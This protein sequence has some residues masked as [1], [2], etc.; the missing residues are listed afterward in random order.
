MVVATAVPLVLFAVVDGSH[1]VVAAIAVSGGWTLLVTAAQIVQRGRISPLILLSLAT[2]ALKCV[3][4]LAAGSSFLFFAIPCGGTAATGAMFAWSATWGSP[5]L[6]RLARDVVPF[7]GPHLAAAASRTLVVRLSWAWAVAYLADATCSFLLLSLAPFHVFLV[8][9]VLA[10]WACLGTA[11]L[12]SVVL[13]R[14]HGP[15]LL[16]LMTGHDHLPTAPGSSKLPEAGAL[17]AA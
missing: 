1:G 17:S 2:L 9:H 11:G 4:A 12:A 3:G 16:R 8:A 7:A 5:L 10:S 13:T 14:R 6:V 15:H